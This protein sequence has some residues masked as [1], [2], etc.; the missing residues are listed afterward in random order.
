MGLLATVQVG[1]NDV[2]VTSSTILVGCGVNDERESTSV[3]AMAK[4]ATDS[5]MTEAH[6][7]LASPD[8]TSSPTVHPAAQ[9]TYGSCG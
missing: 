8:S 6:V 4:F 2:L 9:I 5:P 7:W 3:A 1:S